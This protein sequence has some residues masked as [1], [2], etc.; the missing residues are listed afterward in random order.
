MKRKKTDDNGEEQPLT[1][2][3]DNKS[4]IVAKICQV[5]GIPSTRPLLIIIDV[6]N[7]CKYYHEGTITQ[8]STRA[9]INQFLA[10]K[11]TPHP[12]RDE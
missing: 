7:Q 5:F 8:E 6:Q 11:L 3:Y 1:F 4:S 10:G 12:L 2:L 9:F